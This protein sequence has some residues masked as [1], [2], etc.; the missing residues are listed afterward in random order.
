ML[1]LECLEIMRLLQIAFI[2]GDFILNI[3]IVMNHNKMIL[4]KYIFLYVYVCVACMYAYLN[5]YD[6]TCLYIE[7]WC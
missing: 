3:T 2:I 1:V 6:C 5:V 7:S 4:Q